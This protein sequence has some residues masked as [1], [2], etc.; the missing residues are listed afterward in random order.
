M[1]QALTRARLTWTERFACACGHGFE[2]KNVGLPT[3]GV[4]EALMAQTGRVRVVLAAVPASGKAWP[5]LAKVLDA[6]EG[7]VRRA[8]ASLPTPVWEGTGPEAAFM[9]QALER[10]GATVQLE[11]V[12][13]PP[14]V[15]R[16]SASRARRR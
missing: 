11:P 13:G 8:L 15:S 2:A 12:K 9:R 7:E 16:P 5:V 14:P 3:P 10:S 6:P 4:R 1:V